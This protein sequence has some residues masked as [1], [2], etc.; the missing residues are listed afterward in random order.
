MTDDQDRRSVKAMPVVT[1]E[2]SGRG[3]TFRNFFASFPLCC[4]SRATF[5]TGQ[6]AHNHG[7]TSNIP[8]RGG[9]QSFR[10]ERRTLPVALERAGY[11]TGYV[12][13]YLNGYGDLGTN[14]H[15]VPP[16]W[17]RWHAPLGKTAHR[18]YNYE[19][20]ENGE[21]RSYGKK[22]R[23]Y[24]TDVYVRKATRFIQQSSRRRKPFFLTLA[25]LAPHGEPFRDALPN[26]RPAL[27]HRGRFAGR[28]L[29]KPPSFNEADM[30]DKPRSVRF[31]ARLGRRQTRALRQRH[32]D[33]LASLLAVDN[34]VAGLLRTL[35]RTGELSRTLIIFTSDNGYMLGEHRLIEKNKLYEES[36]GVPLIMRGPGVPSGVVRAQVTANVDLAPTIL[37]V[38][39]A[40]P[41][42]VLDGR[43]LMPLARD[44]SVAAQREILLENGS[45]TAIRTPRYMYAE[46]PKGERELYDLR[47][48]PFQL[49]SRHDDPELAGVEASLASRLDELRDC[50]G[51]SCR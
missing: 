11:R 17:M 47:T 21:I 23:E 9:Y 31:K 41:G 8:P 30:S 10:G 18:M 45:T 50:S 22:P 39:G 48:D 2:L 12:G 15:K 7:V 19:L 40:R 29:P 5:L 49:R 38:G 32:R 4:P 42:R 26:P 46:R 14:R 34:A 6:Y 28:A 13:K 20:N 51:S 3:T 35:R 44:P 27:R 36:A 24:Q 37:D 1:R 25:P 33:R 43:S 16:G